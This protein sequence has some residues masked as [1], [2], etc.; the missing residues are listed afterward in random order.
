MR[1]PDSRFTFE[2]EQCP[3]NHFTECIGPKCGY[4]CEKEKG[5][6]T[7]IQV[8]TARYLAL[9]LERTADAL[10]S[11]EKIMLQILGQLKTRK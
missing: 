11:I 2:V 7:R 1:K 9:N 5:C 4:W 3:I 8:E 10:K 6:A